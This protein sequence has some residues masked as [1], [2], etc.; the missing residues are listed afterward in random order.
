MPENT[1]IETIVEEQ[2]QPEAASE[3]SSPEALSAEG[4]HFASRLGWLPGTT[5]SNTFAE[6]GKKVSA[7]LVRIFASVEEKFKQSPTEDLRW[8]RDNATMIFSEI[9]SVTTEVKP[10]R[11][12]P[13]IRTPKGKISRAINAR[14]A[15]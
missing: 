12:L 5:Q 4:A 1:H 7:A 15:S 11:T 6:R 10:F 13:H 3:S 14:C 9:A 8:L 2:R